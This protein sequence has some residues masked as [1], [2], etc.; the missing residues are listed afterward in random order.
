MKHALNVVPSIAFLAASAAWAQSFTFETIEIPDAVTTQATAFGPSGQPIGYFSPNFFNFE[1]FIDDAGTFKTVKFEGKAGTLLRGANATTLVGDTESGAEGGFILDAS[2][3]VTT[4]MVPGSSATFPTGIDAAGDVFGY[5]YVPSG[6][7][8]E[9]GFILSNGTY[10]TFDYP[11]AQD[12][13]V[14]GINK[15]GEI[16]GSY[17]LSTS[18]PFSGFVYHKGKLT[19]INYPGAYQTSVQGINDAGE[20][21]GYYSTSVSAGNLGFVLNGTTFS[22]FAPPTA[23]NTY[24]YGIN[25]AGQVVGFSLR[26]SGSGPEFG[27]VATP[28]N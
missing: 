5:F 17:R 3:T 25:E 8:E 19:T 4:V 14:N 24:A 10:T 20:I 28:V 27:W 7:P 16:V 9:Q 6:V 26:P 23:T 1:S 15:L 2:G 13:E 18:N 12:T 11:N 21:V 22:S